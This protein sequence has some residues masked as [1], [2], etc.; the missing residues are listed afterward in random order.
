MNTLGSSLD[1]NLFGAGSIESL[2][3]AL[4]FS[5]AISLPITLESA[6]FVR[7]HPLALVGEL[8]DWLTASALPCSI[9][10]WRLHC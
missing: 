3:V 1:V 5:G 4:R 9:T 8:V 10:D 6:L 7:L 2:R